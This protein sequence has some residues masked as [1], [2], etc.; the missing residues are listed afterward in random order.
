MA[1]Q[2][3]T[4]HNITYIMTLV[5][6][7]RKTIFDG[8]YP[9]FVRGFIKDQY[10]GKACGGEDIPQWVLDALASGGISL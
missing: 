9:A 1:A 5:R 8:T 3:L 10:R 6:T 7:M 4:Q 2:L